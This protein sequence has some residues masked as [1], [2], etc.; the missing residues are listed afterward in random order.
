M[1][2]GTLPCHCSVHIL[3]KDSGL[4]PAAA[5]AELVGSYAGHAGM[6]PSQCV[7]ILLG[8]Y[9][10]E[11]RCGLAQTQIEKVRSPTGGNLGLSREEAHKVNK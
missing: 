2:E 4:S 9:I 8:I 7:S 10:F 3:W 1:L 6:F 11:I 5:H